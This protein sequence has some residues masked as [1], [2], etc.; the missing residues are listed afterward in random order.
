MHRRI[1]LALAVAALAAPAASDAA[2]WQP[3]HAKQPPVTAW[4]GVGP[5]PPPGPGLRWVCTS[6]DQRIAG[7]VYTVKT[8]IARPARPR[9]R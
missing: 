6:F 1:A 4:G 8:C 5:L 2:T 7:V 9:A 3:Y